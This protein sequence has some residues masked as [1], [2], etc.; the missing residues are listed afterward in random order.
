MVPGRKQAHRRRQP[1][2]ILPFEYRHQHA[3][4]TDQTEARGQNKRPKQE[5]TIAKGAYHWIWCFHACN[6]LSAT[7]RQF[8][9]AVAASPSPPPDLELPWLLPFPTQ[10]TLQRLSKYIHFN[11][12]QPLLLLG[13]LTLVAPSRRPCLGLG[14]PHL[15]SPYIFRGHHISN[16]SY[17]LSFALLQT[18]YSK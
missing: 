6:L 3:N 4:L 9:L 11:S 7:F 15:P 18:P 17:R 5:A 12:F 16:I 10:H 2:S 8:Y 14:L 13:T 1:S